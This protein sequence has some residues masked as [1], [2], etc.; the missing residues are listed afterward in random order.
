MGEEGVGVSWKGPQRP[1]EQLSLSYRP[2]PQGRARMEQ[3]F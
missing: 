3:E 1:S 2:P